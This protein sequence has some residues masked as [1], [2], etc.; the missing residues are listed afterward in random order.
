MFCISVRRIRNGKF[1]DEPVIG[2]TRY[3]DV[4]AGVTPAPEHQIPRSEWVR[5]VMASFSTGPGGQGTVGDLTLFV[6]GYNTS[7]ASAAR[8]QGR[9]QEGLSAVGFSTTVISFDWPSGTT[10]IGYLEDR[11]DAR[12]TAMRLVT[13]GIRLLIAA[14]RPDC[15]V[16]IHVVAH[17]MGAYVV[18]EA[19]DDADDSRAAESNWTANQ[20][21]LVAGDVSAASLTAGNSSSDSLYRHTA[22]LTNYYNRFDAVLQVSNVKR[23]GLSPRVGRVGLPLLAPAKGVDVDCSARFEDLRQA[24]ELD[25]GDV[26]AGHNFYFNDPTFYKD[27]AATLLG[28]V[29]RIALPTRAPLAGG[30]PNSFML[31]TG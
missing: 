22:R 16:N 28:R 21:V 8:R 13:D 5:R 23:V 10:P 24:E 14:R 19:F 1:D 18:R 27:L 4:P 11:H 2:Q 30:G 6:H 7:V 17:S 20:V 15:E 9:L 12:I 29:D 3:L 25:H 31:K 26:N